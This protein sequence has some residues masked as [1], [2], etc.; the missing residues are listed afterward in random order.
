ML[1]A[2]P[3]VVVLSMASTADTSR[4]DWIITLALVCAMFAVCLT[5]VTR[6][7]RTDL[8]TTRTRRQTLRIKRARHSLWVLAALICL[9]IARIIVAPH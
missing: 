8:E 3:P 4:L 1:I 7:N 9:T 6:G 5:I 2:D